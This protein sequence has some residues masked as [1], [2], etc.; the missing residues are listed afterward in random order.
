MAK[1]LA[2]LTDI[3]GT[4]SSLSFVKDVLFPYSKN[5][6]RSFLDSHW[7]DERIRA[8]LEELFNK[9]GKTLSLEET[10]ELLTKWIDEDRKDTVLKEI[11]GYIW[12]EGYQKGELMGHIYQDAY[13]KLKEWHSRGIKLYVFS[14]GSVK[15]QKLLFSHTPYGDLT[16]LFSGYFDTKVGSKKDPRSYETIAKTINIDPDKVLFL[17][18]LEEELDCAKMAGMKTTRLARDCEVQSKHPTVKDFYSIEI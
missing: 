6:L 16:Y 3:E 17:S 2:V 15:A 1:I 13:K 11:Q 12:E 8:I 14:S 10:L 5:K 18:D 4:T 7:D 9:L